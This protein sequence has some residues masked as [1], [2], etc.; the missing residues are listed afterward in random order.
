[1][2]NFYEIYTLNKYSDKLIKTT[3]LTIVS[4]RKD[5]FNKKKF[6]NRSIFFFIRYREMKEFLVEKSEKKSLEIFFKK[7]RSIYETITS[8]TPQNL[9][10]ISVSNFETIGRC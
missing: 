2:I 9:F 8:R 5:L 1:M 3:E 4:K 10:S 6:E 7:S